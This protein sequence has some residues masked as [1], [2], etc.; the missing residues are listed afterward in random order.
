VY[1]Y[2]AGDPAIRA[3]VNFYPDPVSWLAVGSVIRDDGGTKYGEA[4]SYSDV[5]EQ[6]HTGGDPDWWQTTVFLDLPPGL[7]PGIA[8]VTLTSQSGSTY[9]P[10]PVSI[11]DAGI[12]QAFEFNTDPLGAG[13]AFPLSVSH[14]EALERSTH[15]T[16]AFSGTTIP[17]AIQ[18]ELQHDADSLHGGAGRTFVANPA[19]NRKTI[20]WKDNGQF[21]R[22]IML[23]AGT[24]ELTPGVTESTLDR[25]EALKLYVTGGIQNLQITSVKGFDAQGALI[26]DVTATLK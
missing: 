9:G 10:V 20:N 14:L 25:W 5:I 6:Y 13:G 17:A 16:I 26:P 12:G 7:T 4:A 11:I 8:Q 1:T 19:G 2:N 23:G 24:T 3:A 18:L 15:F 21:L 22:V